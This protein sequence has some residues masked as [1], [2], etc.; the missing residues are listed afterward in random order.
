MLQRNEM[1]FL[2]DACDVALLSKRITSM[3]LA[4]DNNFLCALREQYAN[5]VDTEIVFDGFGYSVNYF[6]DERTRIMNGRLQS[7]VFSGIDC[8]DSS[9]IVRAGF[10][11]YVSDGALAGLEGFP[12]V[13][14]SWPS[15]EVSPAY[16]WENDQGVFGF[17]GD[18]DAEM[19][20]RLPDAEVVV[21]RRMLDAA[22]GVPLSGWP[23]LCM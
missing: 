19:L 13:D 16:E 17:R 23:P 20:R 10:L 7:Y 2:I 14:D 12:S 8:L 4:G 5:V 6:I 21:T 11:L 3:F 18:R 9:G 15:T 22:G 1:V